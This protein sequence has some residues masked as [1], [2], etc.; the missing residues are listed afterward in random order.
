MGEV[1]SVEGWCGFR[2]ALAGHPL[3][4]GVVEM[5]LMVGLCKMRPVNDTF[6][7][8]SFVARS[9]IAG[10]VIQ[11]VIVQETTSTVTVRSINIHG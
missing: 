4:Q 9:V 1:E 7:F 8:H 3:G 10:S 5:S 6:L 11:K 2:C